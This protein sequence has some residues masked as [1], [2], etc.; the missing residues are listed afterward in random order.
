MILRITPIIRKGITMTR[1]QLKSWDEIASALRKAEV[2]TLANKNRKPLA[3][4]AVEILQLRSGRLFDY[5]ERVE[6]LE[7][8]ERFMRD[9]NRSERM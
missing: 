7:C 5:Y 2:E 6:M 4:R 3:H 8:V 9:I 1:E